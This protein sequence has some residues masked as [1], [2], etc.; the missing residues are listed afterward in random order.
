VITRDI[1]TRATTPDWGY[2]RRLRAACARRRPL[3]AAAREQR[4]VRA[5]VAALLA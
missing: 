2:L 1:S 3:F 4:E 5:L